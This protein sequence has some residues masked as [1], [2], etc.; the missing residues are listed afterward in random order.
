MR[1]T[2]CSIW[3]IP[4]EMTYAPTSSYVPPI[5]ACLSVLQCEWGGEIGKGML[6]PG[7]YNGAGYQSNSEV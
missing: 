2:I 6:V 5:H 7:K 1:R 3:V 4:D